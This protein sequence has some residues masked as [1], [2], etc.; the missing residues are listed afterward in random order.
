MNPQPVFSF[1]GISF[2]TQK[3]FADAFPAF[4][5]YAPEVASGEV[6]TVMEL[7]QL[8]RRRRHNKAMAAKAGT[9]STKK[10][11]FARRKRG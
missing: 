7:E 4:R 8:I 2:S 3:A 9:R 6:T 5:S 1:N 11:D 10:I